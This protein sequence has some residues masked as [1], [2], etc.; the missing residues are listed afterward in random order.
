MQQ[1]KPERIQSQCESMRK[2]RGISIKK[3]FHLQYDNTFSSFKLLLLN[4]KKNLRRDF[5]TSTECSITRDKSFSTTF[6]SFY[7][8]TM[9]NSN[10]YNNH[11]NVDSNITRER[12]RKP[13]KELNHPAKSHGILLQF[14]LPSQWW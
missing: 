9:R 11:N 3:L 10:N 1:N 7:I 13:T 5:S 6:N 14:L 2:I 8:S 12:E 4:N